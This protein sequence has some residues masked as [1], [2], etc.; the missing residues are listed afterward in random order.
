MQ[1]VGFSLMHATRRP[2]GPSTQ[3]CW[4]QCWVECLLSCPSTHRPVNR[5]HYPR[6]YPPIGDKSGV[7][8]KENKT[9]IQMGGGVTP[10][11][12]SFNAF[13]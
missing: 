7:W 12:R 13:L 3:L 11:V 10:L 6:S 2:I 1:S 5:S 4:W 9:T 8:P